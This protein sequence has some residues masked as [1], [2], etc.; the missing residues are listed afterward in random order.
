MWEISSSSGGFIGTKRAETRPQRSQWAMK[1]P[2]LT[3][4]WRWTW[5]LSALPKRNGRQDVRQCVS[6]GVLGALGIAGRTKAP[7]LAAERHEEVFL[8]G[9]ALT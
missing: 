1:A 6:G 8:A 9:R 4:A 7:A 2:S 3:T 5:R